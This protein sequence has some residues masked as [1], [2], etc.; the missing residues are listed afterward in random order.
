MKGKGSQASLAKEEENEEGKLITKEERETGAVSFKIYWTWAT[1]AGI[2]LSITLFVLM[3]AQLFRVVVDNW[4]TVWTE[5][6]IKEWGEDD[7]SGDSDV[8]P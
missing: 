5:R 8:R 7:D 3:V 4:I 1:A 6:Q 2:T